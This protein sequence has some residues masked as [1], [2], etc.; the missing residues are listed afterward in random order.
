MNRRAFFKVFGGLVAAAS[1]ERKYFFAPR[2]GWHADEKI[3]VPVRMDFMFGQGVI[4]MPQMRELQ[5]LLT[6]LH[7]Y[8]DP[9]AT[10]RPTYG[11][12]SRASVG[13]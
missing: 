4:I 10:L 11:G 3:I 1:I 2:G 6:G 7:A 13:E 9:L 12:I 5:R 8:H